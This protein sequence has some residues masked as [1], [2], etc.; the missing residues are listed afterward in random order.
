MAYARVYLRLFTESPI[1]MK[2]QTHCP[3][4]L[5]R[6]MCTDNNDLHQED[7]PLE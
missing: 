6:L 4:Y 7:M 3:L 1:K 5:K 2:L